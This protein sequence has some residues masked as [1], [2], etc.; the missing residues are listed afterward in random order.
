MKDP[1][2]VMQLLA[3]AVAAHAAG[4][5]QE[6]RSG[7]GRVLEV[8]PEHLD[9]LR[10]LAGVQADQGDVDEAIA[11]TQEVLRLHDHAKDHEF[12]S[13]LL[14]A[15]RRR[16][17]ALAHIER[18]IELDAGVASA[19]CQRG[20]LLVHAGRLQEAM[21][22]FEQALHTEPGHIDSLVGRGLA[23]ERLNRLDEAVASH[24]RAIELDP[25]G[26]AP[27]AG[28]ARLHQLMGEFGQ[29]LRLYDQVIERGSG[30]DRAAARYGKACTLLALGDYA[31]GWPLYE[32][33]WD[34]LPRRKL[35]SARWTGQESLEGRTLLLYADQGLGDTLMNARFAADLA[36]AGAQVV[37]EV[38]PSLVPLLQGQCGIAQVRPLG[39][40]PP[41]HDFNC[42]LFSLPAA[43]RLRL[44]T[45][46]AR[47][48]YL[49]A[50]PAR[51]AQWARRLGPRTQPRVGLAWSGYGGHSQDH[52]RSIPFAQF[53]SALPAGW[54]YVSLQAHAR[55]HEC[56][57]VESFAPMRRFESELTDFAETAALVSQLDL[58]VTVD[59]SVAH[60]A[61]AL[62]VPNW[63]LL[64]HPPDYRWLAT[65]EW[66]PWYARSKLLRQGPDQSWPPVLQRVRRDLERWV[67]AGDLVLAT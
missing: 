56:Q 64:H 17:E 21:A 37:M 42:P 23:Y 30:K 58:V 46:P 55:P 32:H 44:D 49:R 38:Q 14:T 52:R 41:P 50:D 9:A 66:C 13:S 24:E 33:R 11:A 1:I 43:L 53:A 67:M 12:M 20:T 47:A 60:L 59:T 6:A 51:K 54:D 8:D 5:L 7:Y 26:V 2:A 27:L 61:G 19:H 16:A 10:L 62:G 35:P 18:S 34:T 40:Q 29:A 15:A 25:D 45:V 39:G 22:S 65:G 28:R 3:Q 63:I 4:D 57:A 36:Q 31:Q 48:G